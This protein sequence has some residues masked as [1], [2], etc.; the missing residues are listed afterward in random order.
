MLALTVLL[1]RGS[2]LGP[3]AARGSSAGSSETDGPLPATTDSID[4]AE[5]DP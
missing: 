1:G 4:D 5:D 2:S 3:F